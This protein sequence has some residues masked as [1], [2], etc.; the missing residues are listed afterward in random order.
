MGNLQQADR[1][2]G[3]IYNLIK[4]Q[5]NGIPLN[6]IAAKYPSRDATVPYVVGKL[7]AEKK[8]STQSCGS[9]TL[10]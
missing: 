5:K 6:E 3:K 9:I 2:L 8:T 1:E 10:S 4:E 7:L